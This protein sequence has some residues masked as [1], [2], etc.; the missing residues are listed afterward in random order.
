MYIRKP[1]VAGA[2]YPSDA[3]KLRKMIN[4]FL[5]AVDEKEK[6]TDKVVGIVSPHA[7]YIYSGPVAAYGFKLLKNATYKGYVVISPSHRARFNGA[8]VLPEGFYSTPLGNV[9]VDSDIGKALTLKNLFA[10]IPEIDQ[11]EHSLEVQIPFLQLVCSDFKIVPVVIGT[12][13]LNLCSEIGNLIADEVLSANK[14]Y[15]VIISTDLS[16]YYSYETAKR[17]DGEFARALSLFD[18]KAIDQAIKS[19]KAE[20]CGEGAVLSGIAL[21]KRLG[22]SKAKILK[23]ANSG[24]TAGPKNEVVGYISA[25]LLA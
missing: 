4:G 3:E 25:A 7:G 15:G 20:A 5:A 8:S 9:E 19:K 21:A 16:H 17:I 24:D 10:Y 22:A 14:D 2:F 1:S 11:P 23:Y 18:E 6:I 12:T 13:D